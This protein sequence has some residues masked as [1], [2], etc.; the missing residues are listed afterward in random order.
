MR[1]YEFVRIS[2]LVKYI[3][4]CREIGLTKPK[5]G[6]YVFLLLQVNWVRKWGK[7]IYSSH[8]W[9]GLQSE[10]T[11]SCTQQDEKEDK[12]AMLSDSSRWKNLQEGFLQHCGRVNQLLKVQ[13]YFCHSLKWVQWE[14]SMSSG[15]GTSGIATQNN[16]FKQVSKR[17]TLFKNVLVLHI[18]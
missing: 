13:M 7:Q 8:S 16:N 12:E 18:H 11:S 9:W 17:Y 5:L 6:N 2:H 14:S 4:N 15:I 3:R 1:S 10:V